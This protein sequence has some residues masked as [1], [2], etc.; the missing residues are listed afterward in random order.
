MIRAIKTHVPN[1]RGV[2]VGLQ[3]QGLEHM[4]TDDDAWDNSPSPEAALRAD[5]RD[6]RQK[7]YQGYQWEKSHKCW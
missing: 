4:L 3:I 6:R 5:R 1:V 2:S 7:R